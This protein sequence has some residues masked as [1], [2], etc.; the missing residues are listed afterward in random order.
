MLKYVKLFFLIVIL[1]NLSACQTS[2][3][4]STPAKKDKSIKIAEINLQLG[5]GYL[6]KGNIQRA[7]QKLLIALKKGPKLPEAWYS[8]G[9]YLENTGEKGKANEY[10]LK[11]ID[12]APARGDT[13]N[14][15]GT[16]LCRMGQ[17]REAIKHF[18]LATKDPEYLDSAGAYEN[19]GLCAL[20]IPNNKL[21]A[22]YFKQALAQDQHRTTSIIEL[23]KITREL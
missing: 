7:K 14:N 16:Y 10:Y 12:L 3:K 6:E 8:M 9:Y 13:Q 18:I 1:V 11:A 19:A 15:Y 4:S 17:Y 20:K 2:T 21:A 5:M 22:N 23:N